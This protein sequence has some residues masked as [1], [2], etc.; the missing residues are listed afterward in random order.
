MALHPSVPKEFPI[1]LQHLI[2]GNFQPTYD[3]YQSCLSPLPCS[4]VCRLSSESTATANA[5]GLLKSFEGGVWLA[6][7]RVRL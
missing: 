7:S 3:I 2:G 1:A 4:A 6:C 5:S